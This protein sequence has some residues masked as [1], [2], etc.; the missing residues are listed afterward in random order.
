MQG[1]LIR[2]GMYRVLHQRVPRSTCSKTRLRIL[3]AIP[4][5]YRKNQR[6]NIPVRSIVATPHFPTSWAWRDGGSVTR[7]KTQSSVTK[8]LSLTSTL[9][10]TFTMLLLLL[11]SMSRST[12][13][14]SELFLLSSHF[15]TILKT[16]DIS[17]TGLFFRN[18]LSYLTLVLILLFSTYFE[19][20]DIQVG[21]NST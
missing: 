17:L 7:D 10:L 5:A 11:Y 19:I 18:Q 13:Q 3:Y 16:Q 1:C 15:Y 4:S 20:W 9:D 6:W 14:F 8:T 2:L 12:W 21:G